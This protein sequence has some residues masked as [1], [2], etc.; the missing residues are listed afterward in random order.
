MTSIVDVRAIAA[1]AAPD[2]K[3]FLM[4]LTGRTTSRGIASPTGVD[5]G[6]LAATSVMIFVSFPF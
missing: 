5:I 2:A 3:V 4:A 1:V 6:Y